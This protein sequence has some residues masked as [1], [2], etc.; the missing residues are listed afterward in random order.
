MNPTSVKKYANVNST[1]RLWKLMV[2]IIVEPFSLTFVPILNQLKFQVWKHLI[3]G[4]KES[5]LNYILQ[6]RFEFICSKLSI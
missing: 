4:L 1:T 2:R 5:K 6:M 3:N